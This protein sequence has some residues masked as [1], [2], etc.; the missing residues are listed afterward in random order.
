MNDTEWDSWRASWADSQGPL[1]DVRTAAAKQ[2]S[3]HRRANW[4][5]F[6][7]LGGGALVNVWA[8]AFEDADVV[9]CVG[10]LI[11]GTAVALGVAWIQRGIHLQK[12]AGPRDAVAFLDRRLRVERQAAQLFRWAYAAGIVATGIYL[13]ICSETSGR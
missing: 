13:E 5:L 11:W 4:M 12:T 7:L 9:V 10:L 3:R 6:A 1:P 8:A 2:A